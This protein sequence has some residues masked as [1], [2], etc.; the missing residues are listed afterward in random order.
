MI[1]VVNLFDMF[2]VTSS[3]D[4]DSWRRVNGTPTTWLPWG[5]EALRLGS[6]SSIREWD[7][8]IQNTSDVV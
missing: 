6:G 8:L 5:T 2:F 3:D 7:M 1:R 4:V